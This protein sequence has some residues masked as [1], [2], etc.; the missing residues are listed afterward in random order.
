VL[1]YGRGFFGQ[2][3]LESTEALE[4][5]EADRESM[6]FLSKDI[7]RDGSCI[8][9]D[10]GDTRAGRFNADFRRTAYE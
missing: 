10:K 4:K 3:D 6:E 1:F 5:I 2:H 7:P 8:R 9:R